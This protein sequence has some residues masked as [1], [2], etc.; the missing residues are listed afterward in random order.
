MKEIIGQAKVREA[1]VAG[2]FYPDD[3]SELEAKVAALL[4]AAKP[5]IS[6]AKR[7]SL[8]TRGTRLFR[9]PVRPRMEVRGEGKGRYRTGS[10][11]A[12]PGGRKPHLSARVGLFRH[13]YGQSSGRRLARRGDEGLRNPHE[14]QR[15][16]A[17]RGT[18]HRA[19]ASLHA[20]PIALGSPCARALRQA[21]RRGSQGPGIG[22]RPGLLR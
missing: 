7:H 11:S 8:A 2:I 17:F 19:P 4:E 22:P 20:R 1:T 13:T 15:H 18:R 10:L 12:A 14:R 16:P 3:P 5:A 21:Q 9:R 6:N